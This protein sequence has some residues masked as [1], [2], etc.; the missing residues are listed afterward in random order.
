MQTPR[1]VV[2]PKA[3]A[4]ARCSDSWLDNLG[5][6]QNSLGLKLR[7]CLPPRSVLWNKWPPSCTT[8]RGRMF[9][10]SARQPQVPEMLSCPIHL[11]LLF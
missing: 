4:G 7:T 10:H 9:L 6:F 11:N 5:Y 8:P 2:T 1:H 3:R